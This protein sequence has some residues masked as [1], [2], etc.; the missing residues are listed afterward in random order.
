MAVTISM[1]ELSFLFGSTC[2]IGT[3][4]MWEIIFGFVMGLSKIWVLL[5]STGFSTLRL[6]R[7]VHDTHECGWLMSLWAALLS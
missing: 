5:M 1:M 4:I 7:K 2:F 3:V 6:S